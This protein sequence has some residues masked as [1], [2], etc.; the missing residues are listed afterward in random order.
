MGESLGIW[1][2]AP[3]DS[4]MPHIDACNVAAG[5]HASD[6]S[7]LHKTV[8]LAKKHGVG[9]GAHPGFP[10]L[11]GFG[12]RRMELTPQEVEDIIVYQVGAVKGFCE[13]EGVKLVSLVALLT[14][15]EAP[16]C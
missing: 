16:P 6:P 14:S 9:C 15:S 4:I 5:F 12:R 3:D 2:L 11:V 10:D 13:Y 7:T 1:R 8:L